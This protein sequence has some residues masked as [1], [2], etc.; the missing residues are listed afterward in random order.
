ML[1]LCDPAKLITDLGRSI[2]NGAMDGTKTGKFYGDPYGQ[3]VATLKA[4]ARK[5]EI[6]FSIP[7]NE[8]SREGKQ[9]ALLGCGEESNDVSWE[10]LRKKRSGTHHF[11]GRWQ[12]LLHLVNGEYARKHADQ[13]GE[14]MMNVM[15]RME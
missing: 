8:L 3:Y 9:L 12:G 4:V 13:R 11:K 2:L 7:W 14:S 6:D 15:S 5:H 1:I 10:F